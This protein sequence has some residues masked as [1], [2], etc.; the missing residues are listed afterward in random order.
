MYMGDVEYLHGH[1]DIGDD[2]NGD[3][4]PTNTTVNKDVEPP[5]ALATRASLR[6]GQTHRPAVGIDVGVGE[7][8]PHLWCQR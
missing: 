5:T 4:P 2:N 6:N 7:A 8:C 3:V 1:N